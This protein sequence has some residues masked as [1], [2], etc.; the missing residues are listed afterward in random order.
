MSL[1]FDALNRAQGYA[2]DGDAHPDQLANN[3]PTATGHQPAAATSLLSAGNRPSPRLLPFIVAGLVLLTG[4]AAW[5]YYQY[6]QLSSIS[7]EQAMPPAA[8]HAAPVMA[9]S[10]FS[11]AST[12]AS[13]EPA[14]NKQLI[15]ADSPT[16]AG[17]PYETV[18]NS[19]KPATR[20]AG[21]HS[22]PRKA[23]SGIVA[24]SGKDPLQEGYLALSQG[25]LEQAEQNYQ[26]ALAQH[27]HEKDAMLGLAVIAQRR[28][29]SQ[30]A[31]D[32]YRQVLRE[33]IGNAT[34]AAGL[35]SLSEQADPVAAES[36]LKQLI[37]LKSNAPE[38]HYALGN[39]LARQ[40]RWGEAQQAFF[41]AHG[42]APT[43]ALYAYNLAVSLEHLHQ[44]A[45]ALPFYVK[46]LQLVSAGDA[47]LDRAA[48][49]KRI[50]ELQ[51]PAPG[52]L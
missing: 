4:V 31:T 41:R 15:L 21:I 3:A 37:D 29:Q 36:Q 50:S 9:A 27:P 17:A 14:A 16:G 40:Q 20:P 47:T 34:A 38:F 28:M 49:Q 11:A 39:V 30:R 18:A 1:L 46:A 7:P 33:D 13:T 35:V 42:L 24:S 48:V 5:L 52:T 32:L 2:Q 19:R 26:L 8:M 44:S 6:S 23:A 12:V 25:R 45:A 22:K 51:Q 10:Q 43:N